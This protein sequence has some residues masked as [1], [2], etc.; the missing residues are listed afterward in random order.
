M[1]IL[2]TGGTG[3][4]GSALVP[5]LLDA[6]HGVTILSRAGA[7]DQPACRYVASLDE[8]PADQAVDAVINLAGASLADKRWTRRYKREIFSSRLDT[9]AAVIELCQRLDGKPA[10]LLSASAIGYYGHHGD[11]ELAEDGAVVA[12]FSQDLCQRWEAEAL[13]AE[14]LGVRV[15]L[16]RLG[17]V[18][19]EGGGA[20]VEMARP[21]RFG[22]ANWVGNGRQWLSWVHRSD[23]V[24]AILFLL[25][26]E[27]LSGPFN[28]TA[29]EPVTGRG[30]CQAMKRQ[31]KT[32]ATAPV[33]GAVLRLMVGE[34]AGELL[35]RGQRV[36]PAALT[37]A[38]FQFRYGGLDEA[39]ASI[40][41]D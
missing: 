24:E 37:E 2:V 19:D 29:P 13:R 6:G 38:G 12:G 11:E 14:E 28:L 30:F 4:I 18:L 15:C 1:E 17:V 8:I 7:G 25:R 40:F 35:L 22:I 23:V 41:G 32:V 16:M 21:F 26:E 3:F 5:A 39:L 20:L 34:M 9:T 36:V 27:R 33:P 10:V 31:F